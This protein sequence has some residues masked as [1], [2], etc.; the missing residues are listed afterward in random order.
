MSF[1]FNAAIAQAKTEVDG[2]KKLGVILLGPSGSGKSTAIGKLNVKTLF[3][4]A[5][6]ESHGAAAATTFGK[7]NI[8]PVCIDR[9]SEGNVLS[10]G[11]ARE[12]LLEIL[13]SRAE[14]VEA[15]IEAIAIDGATELEAIVKGSPV[16]TNMV[17]GNKYKETDV[18][19]TLMREIILK[20]KD[21]QTDLGLHYIVTCIL[22]QKEQ[23]DNGEIIDSQPRLVG[24]R[25]ADSVVQL[26][27]D[28]VVV[29]PMTN[30]ETTQHRFQFLAGVSKEQ[31]DAASGA[32]KKTTNFRPR[33]TGVTLGDQ[34]T[35]GGTMEADLSVL[36]K[37][38][39]GE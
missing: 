2:Q 19:I 21:L 16:Y 30:G 4:Y 14:L 18:T 8:I 9:D 34:L 38:K 3:L 32:M 28:V 37:I 10:A 24:Y 25:V 13:D 35:A 23:S 11:L 6:G 15:G 12:R 26:F 33:I 22:D 1:D 29:G 7:D 36:A 39:A 31:K 27:P 17:A 20:L 5:R